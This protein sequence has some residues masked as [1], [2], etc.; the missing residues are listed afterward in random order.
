MKHPDFKPFPR[1]ETDPHYLAKFEKVVKDYWNDKA[2]CNYGGKEYSYAEVATIIEKMHMI[3]EA[4]GVKKGDKVTLCARN[5]AE[6]AISFLAIN[7]Y[8]AV[9]VPLLADF[10]PESINHLVDHSDSVALFSDED[11][12]PKLDIAQMPKV[13]T[14]VDINDFSLFHADKKVEKAYQ[15]LDKDFA[16]K[17]PQGFGPDNVH[18]PTDNAKDLAVINYTS[19]TTSAPKGVMLRY[20]CFSATIDY[21]HR[22]LPNYHGENIVS[23][24]PMGHIYGL[25]YEFLYPLCGGVCVY[26]LGKT[27]SPSL[28]LKAMKEVKPYIVITVPLV[29]EKV[30][31]SGVAPALKKL[32]L[33]T[34]LPG[35]SGVIYKAAG[36]KLLEA[37]GG[38][39]RYF[40]M[41]GA[42]LNPKVE[43][44]F[45]KMQLPYTVGYGM[46]E[47]APLLA[48]RCWWEYAPGS[49]GQAVDCAEVRIDSE[50]PRG[51]AG[52]ILAKGTNICSG[53]YKYPEA[54]SAVFT[55]DGYLHT[56]DLGTI[57]KDGNIFIRGRS[58]TMFLSA[59][60]QNIYPEEL[61]A[62]INSRPYVA[63]SVV[64]DR[65]GKLVALVFLDQKAIEDAKLTP[66]TVSDIPED[67]RRSSNRK[68]PGYSQIAKVEIVTAPF[69]KT[70]KM[71]IKRF[72]YS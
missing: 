23:M 61:E 44:A 6:W 65:G 59:N 1:Q 27:P 68:L 51:I 22:Y 10:L 33:L 4:S 62:V 64:V 18:Y 57:D 13:K 54:D 42:A 15:N 35:I 28:L 11:I 43:T 69:E 52:E 47:A 16:A 30:F 40:I 48:F 19:G 71:S 14:V 37:F 50:D 5:T 12:W 63:E 26:Y 21:G 2:I 25:T 60:G 8:E 17:F 49:C 31:K 29:M 45:K 38:N 41:G 20:E 55:A 53:Y 3:L 67:I 36:K 58:K 56:G 66:E 32:G 70:P 24:L 39:V 9:V 7:T 46:T 72:L 34:K